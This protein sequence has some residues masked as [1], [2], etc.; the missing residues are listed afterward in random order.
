[1]KRALKWALI[2]V[3]GLLVITIAALLMLLIGGIGTLSGALIGAAI[4]KLMEF[5]LDKFFGE[6][7]SFVI[8][9]VYILLVLFLPYGIVG[10]W[11][12][13]SPRIKEGQG[14]LVKMFTGGGGTLS[15]EE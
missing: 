13:K 8:G 15:E 11:R 12:Q 5:G 9:V 1:M 7:A 4:Y 10:T 6:N 3:G 14:R 2:I